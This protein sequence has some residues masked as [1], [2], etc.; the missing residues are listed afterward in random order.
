[1][2]EIDPDFCIVDF[3]LK[4]VSGKNEEISDEAARLHAARLLYDK[5]TT[6]ARHDDSDDANLAQQLLDLAIKQAS[7]EKKSHE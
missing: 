1:M 7:S 5:S 2:Q 4:I 3:L 6:T